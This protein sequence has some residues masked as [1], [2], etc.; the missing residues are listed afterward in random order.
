MSNRAPC[1]IASSASDEAIQPVIARSKATKQSSLPLCGAV[2]DCFAALAMTGIRHCEERK[3]RSNP[4]F[5]FVAQ[6][7]IASLRSQ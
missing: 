1:V 5:G 6:C 4:A 3:R 2:L 7:W